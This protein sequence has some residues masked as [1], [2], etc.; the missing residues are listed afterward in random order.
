MVGPDS[1]V[2]LNELEGVCSGGTPK[3]NHPSATGKLVQ[4]YLFFVGVMSHF[5]THTHRIWQAH[6]PKL[7]S[8]PRLIVTTWL[9]MNK[10][11]LW[12][13]HHGSSLVCSWLKAIVSMACQGPIALC[14]TSFGWIIAVDYR[15]NLH[16]H[17]FL[18]HESK[19]ERSQKRD[20]LPFP[21]WP[22]LGL[23]Y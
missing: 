20:C 12:S 19:W 22:K 9:D 18:V 6:P 16:V 23:L 7:C 4:S 5:V 21:I 8:S 11:R 2:V 15:G 14:A 10:T 1:S 17:G 3:K 13:F